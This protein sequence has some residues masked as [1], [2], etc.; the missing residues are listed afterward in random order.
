MRKRYGE[1]LECLWFT[2]LYSCV[3]PFGS[4]LILIGLTLYYWVDKYNLLRRSSILEGVSGS[5]CMD[6]LFLMEFTLIL[7]PGGELIFD[8]L[9]RDQWNVIPLVE[10]CI[11]TA[12][13]FLPIKTMLGFLH[14]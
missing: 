5:L 1:I 8:G 13:I 12:Y 11:G 6:A 14:P 3:I 10:I 2:Y 7:K 4:I 9:I